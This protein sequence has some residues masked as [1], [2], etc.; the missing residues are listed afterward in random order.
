MLAI[1]EAAGR[2]RR[3]LGEVVEVEIVETL[4]RAVA[5]AAEIARPGDVVLLSPACS[6]YDQ[7]AHYEER[8]DRFRAL[9]Q[10]LGARAGAV[11]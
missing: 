3:E 4:D 8:G 1:G 9:V 10:A 7:F 11:S 2:I 5:R 6:S